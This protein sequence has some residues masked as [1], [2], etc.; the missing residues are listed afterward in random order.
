MGY[1]V[2]VAGATGAVGREIIKT[3]AEREFPVDEIVALAS[4]RSVEGGHRYVLDALDLEPMFDLDMRLGEGT[5]AALAMHWVEAA[6]R[7]LHEMSTFEAAGVSDSG[8]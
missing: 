5:G 2:A 6:L 4:H 3:L 1:R 7:V 8:A